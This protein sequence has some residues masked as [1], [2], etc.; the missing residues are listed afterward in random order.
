MA[1]TRIANKLSMQTKAKNVQRFFIISFLLQIKGK[2]Q[3]I[4]QCC[5]V[6]AAMVSTVAEILLSEMLNHHYF[7]FEIDFSLF[8][9]Q[10][11]VQNGIIVFQY[12]QNS[13]ILFE[14]W[15]ALLRNH[16]KLAKVFGNY[17]K[18]RN[19]F[20][21]VFLNFNFRDELGTECPTMW[22]SL[23][24]KCNPFDFYPIVIPCRDFFPSIY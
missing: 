23:N 4:Q 10:P 16:R 9:L 14:I 13:Y 20:H 12:L 8:A 7:L 3:R 19:T 22:K 18:L 17:K 6:M 21:W 11:I 2:N 15:V 1:C 5:A 24:F